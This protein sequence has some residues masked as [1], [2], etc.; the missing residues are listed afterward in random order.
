MT[1]Q[2]FDFSMIMRGMPYS[3]AMVQVLWQLQIVNKL[4]LH[5][6]MNL[7]WAWQSLTEVGYFCFLNLTLAFAQV[8]ISKV[9]KTK[10]VPTRMRRLRSLC[11]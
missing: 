5:K 9:F 2:R 4:V 6:A 10:L 1:L 7:G 8:L 11:R 3:F